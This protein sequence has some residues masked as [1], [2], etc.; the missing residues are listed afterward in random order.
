VTGRFYI[1]MHSTENLDDGYLGSGKILWRSIK[2]Y[3][4]NHHSLE[5]IENC[6]SR[7]VLREREKQLVNDD[8]LKDELCM[9]LNR[10]GDGGWKYINDNFLC[11]R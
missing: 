3:G 2:K 1:G 9:N 6:E 11:P 5:I 7:E 10:G 8:L 4:K